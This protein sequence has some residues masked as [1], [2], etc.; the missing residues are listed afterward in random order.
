MVVIGETY[1]LI[2]AVLFQPAL[3]CEGG[4]KTYVAPERGDDGD[5]RKAEGPILRSL[6]GLHHAHIVCFCCVVLCPPP[7]VCP[8]SGLYKT[9]HGI[10]FHL[11]ERERNRSHRWELSQSTNQWSWKA[12][13]RSLTQIWAETAF[14]SFT[15]CS[16]LLKKRAALHVHMLLQSLLLRTEMLRGESSHASVSAG[17]ITFLGR[18]FP[19]GEEED[20]FFPFS[21]SWCLA[22]SQELGPRRE[23]QEEASF[24]L[25]YKRLSNYKQLKF[26]REALAAF[27]LHQNIEKLSLK[28][29]SFSCNY[30]KM[31][32]S[33]YT[34]ETGSSVS[35]KRLHSCRSKHDDDAK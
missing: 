24:S 4:L 31:W 3:L 19:L 16:N 20:V 32:Y 11:V 26:A 23:E 35:L 34:Y 25:V 27:T 33:T 1:F 5:G 6:G 9:L 30:F 14:S 2:P 15:T 7:C 12:S 17:S 28:W 8:Q 29:K 10:L 21:L 18:C 13:L 22:A